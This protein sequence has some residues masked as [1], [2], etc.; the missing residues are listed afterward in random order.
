MNTLV[1]ILLAVIAYILWRIYRQREDEKADEG[2][3][4]FTREKEE[5]YR[6]KYPHLVDNLEGNW[7]HVFDQYTTRAEDSK[8]LLKLAFLLYL[9][10]S[11]KWDLEGSL[12]FDRLWGLSEELLEHIRKYHEGSEDEYLIALTTYWQIS[13]E[14]CENINKDTDGEPFR[15]APFRDIEKITSWFP[16]KQNHPKEELSFVDKKTGLFP[17]EDKGSDLIREELKKL[18][19]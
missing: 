15:V 10:E 18:G 8:M 19:L 16:K 5:R 14:R 17:R 9:K 4:E 12:V 7:L 3:E 13:A 6:K 2:L 11:T 1:I